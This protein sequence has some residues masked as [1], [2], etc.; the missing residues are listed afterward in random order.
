MQ[1]NL[2]NEIGCTFTYLGSNSYKP[3]VNFQLEVF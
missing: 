3:I 2:T 1:I